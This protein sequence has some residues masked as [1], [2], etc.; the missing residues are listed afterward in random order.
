M[1][2]LKYGIPLLIAGLAGMANENSR[3]G[4]N[5]AAFTG[6]NREKVKMAFTARVIKWP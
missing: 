2:M 1:K 5:P 3:Q 6:R 4:I